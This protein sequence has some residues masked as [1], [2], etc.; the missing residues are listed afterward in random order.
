MGY[1]RDLIDDLKYEIDD[2]KYKLKK[3]NYEKATKTRKLNN[4][5]EKIN[6]LIDHNK[7]IQN[8]N[9]I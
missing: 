7:I 1:Y 5:K 4:I 2:L 8:N 6:W 9:I 3:S